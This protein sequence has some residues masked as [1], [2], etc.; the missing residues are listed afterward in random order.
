RDLIVFDR[1]GQV[2]AASAD[3]DDALSLDQLPRE[4]LEQVQAGEPFSRLEPDGAD[5]YVI[6]TA[7]AVP[8]PGAQA[9]RRFVVAR[10]ALPP[11][12]SGLANALLQVQRNYGMLELSSTQIKR[13][14]ALTQVL[15]LMLAML[16]A[17]YLAVR[18]ARRLTRPVHDLIEG[19]RAVGKGDFG[20]KLPLPSR[21]EM[22]Y[23]V[24]SFND[25]TKRLRRASEEA[26]RSR[27]LVEAE[28]E[29]LAV[30]LAGLSTGVIVVDT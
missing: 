11:E 25:M 23:L 7:A 30:I 9:L 18:A 4:L 26:R 29:R 14:F 20:T 3:G 19:T 24:H 8:D 28:R 15:V 13:R 27:T 10:H 16:S 21:D 17:M 2:L 1:R 5:G 6:Y 12:L 22:G